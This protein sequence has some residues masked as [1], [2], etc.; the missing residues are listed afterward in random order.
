MNDVKNGK[1][2]V[3]AKII[4]EK[5]SYTEIKLIFVIM[6]LLQGHMTELK[7]VYKTTHFDMLAKDIKDQT[8]DDILK[9][10]LLHAVK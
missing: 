10:V 3:L 5:K 1:S 9:I 2:P 8:T 7:Q 4:K 6:F